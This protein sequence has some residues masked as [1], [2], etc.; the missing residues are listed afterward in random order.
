MNEQLSVLIDDSQT[1]FEENYLTRTYGQITNRPDLALT[2]LVANAWDSGADTVSIFISSYDTVEERIVSVEDNGTGMTVE[3]FMQRWMTLGYNRLLRQGEFANVPFGNKVKK[4]RAYGRNGIGRHSLLCFGNQYWVETWK[5]GILNT[6]LIAQS[7]GNTALK[8]KKHTSSVRE[9]HGTKVYASIDKNYPN[10]KEVSSVLSARFMYDPE[11]ELS[12]NGISIGLEEFEGG[13]VTEVIEVFDDLTIEVTALSS[14]KTARR[15]H[16]HGVAFWVNKRL[17]GEP[18]WMLGRHN[19]AD[20]RT[21]IARQYTIIVQSDDLLN[22]VNEDW[23]HL[24]SNERIDAVY[25]K[26]EEFSNTLLKEINQ[27][28]NQEFKVQLLKKYTDEFRYINYSAR[29]E[30]M[31]LVDQVVDDA[32]DLSRGYL[33][34]T[35]SKL[36]D[37]NKSKSKRSLVE[38]IFSLTDR[39]AEKLSS[40]LADW[41]VSDIE[42]VLDEVDRRIAAIEAIEKF[43]SLEGVDE[44]HVLHPLM[45][46]S[47]WLFGA[48]FDSSFYI[49]NRRLTTILKKYLKK[50][51]NVVDLSSPKKRPDI[52]VFDDTSL[53]GYAT[54]E[55]NSETSL[56]DYRRLLLIEIKGGGKEISSKEVSQ[57]EEYMAELFYSNAFNS[58]IRIDAFTVGASVN[59]RVSAIREYKDP[60]GKNTWG[61]LTPASYSQLIGTA[62][63]RLFGLKKQLSERYESMSPKSLL[64]KAVDEEKAQISLEQLQRNGI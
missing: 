43:S 32:P 38:K 51:E 6:F 37:I 34:L 28:K 23:T 11:F 21:T 13:K 55:I 47:K 4:R 58:N 50:P 2:E 46:E 59:E 17:V 42:Y 26:V 40:I 61:K 33:D 29:R 39:D 19:I 45:L 64:E 7:G 25:D 5:D 44:L 8:I 22:E 63:K 14:Q 27:E 15:S 30:V 36:I 48:E 56:A 60:T 57:T 54:E 16:Q 41:D 18:S 3:E 20:G 9:G 10:I 49:S 52:I 1:L 24:K 53:I 62:E 35:V 31:E 12:V